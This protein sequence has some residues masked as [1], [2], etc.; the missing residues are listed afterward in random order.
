MRKIQT[1]TIR[2]AD[3]RELGPDD[4][5][6]FYDRLDDTTLTNVMKLEIDNS[7]VKT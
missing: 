1:S 6:Y 2:K 3:I 4:P 5:Q 7:K